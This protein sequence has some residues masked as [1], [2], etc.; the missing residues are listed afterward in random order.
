MYLKGPTTG[1]MRMH[2]HG[3]RAPVASNP[4]AL[5]DIV[6]DF[7][8]GSA[9]VTAHAGL[10]DAAAGGGCPSATPAEAPPGLFEIIDN[11]D[12]AV[13]DGVGALMVNPEAVPEDASASTIAAY[14]RAHV[15]VAELPAPA[16]GAFYARASFFDFGYEPSIASEHTLVLQGGAVQ[17]ETRVGSAWFPRSKLKYDELLSIFAFNFNLRPYSK[18]K[19][20]RT[21]RT[22]A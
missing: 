6:T 19:I 16:P 12:G 15:V 10:G 21:S 17:G 22:W 3:P 2:S 14:G 5:F 7:E 9:P 8:P 20:A 11:V 1:L 4:R 18:A 13:F